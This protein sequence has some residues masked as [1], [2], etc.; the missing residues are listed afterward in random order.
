MIEPK[1]DAA[2]HRMSDYLSG[3]NTFRVDT[4]TVDE[5]KVAKDGRKIQELA[6]SKFAVRRPGEMRIAPR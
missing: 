3:L 6:E 5:T 2:L 1:A 4:T